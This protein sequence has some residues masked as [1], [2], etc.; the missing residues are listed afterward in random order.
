MSAARV[1]VTG[2][3]GFI[4]AAVVRHLL[5]GGHPVRAAVRD[6]GR[7]RE[8]LPPGTDMAAVGELGPQADWRTALAGVDVVVHTAGRAHVL[9]ETAA[10]PLAAFRAINV[11]ATL[12]LA[13]QAVSAGVRRFVFLSSVGVLG[14][15]SGSHPLRADDLPAPRTPY[16]RSKLEAE[17]GLCAF[18]DR[19]EIVV[20]RLP[21]VHGP[22]ARGNFARLVAAVRHGWPLPLATVDNRRSLLGIDNLVSLIACCLDHPAAVGQSFLA[23]DG[24]EI[25]TPGLVRRIAAVLDRPA[26]LFPLPT[27]ALRLALRATGHAAAA[28]GLLDSLQIDDA[29]TRKALQWQ[30]PFDLTAGLRRAVEGAC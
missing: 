12:A 9:S 4:G 27:G 21:L 6:A 28:C 22:A 1:L 19:M 10:D 24:E 7:A 8:A 11:D 18:A 2:A 20:L 15:A 30:P 3:N 29:A 25:S 14:D 5:D 26:R 16:A 17:T 23:A 13:H